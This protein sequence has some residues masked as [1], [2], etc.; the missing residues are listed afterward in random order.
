M[1]LHQNNLKSGAAFAQHLERAGYVWRNPPAGRIGGWTPQSGRLAID[2]ILLISAFESEGFNPTI[3]SGTGADGMLQVTGKTYRGLLPE[4]ATKEPDTLRAM[5]QRSGVDVAARGWDKLAAAPLSRAVKLEVALGDKAANPV[6]RKLVENNPNLARHQL[7][8][9]G[10]NVKDLGWDKLVGPELTAAIQTRLRTATEFRT[11]VNSGRLNFDNQVQYWRFME[12][13]DLGRLH[14]VVDKE[15][16]QQPENSEYLPIFL[17]TYH[18]LGATQARKIIRALVDGQGERTLTDI[19]IPRA[20]PDNNPIDNN[21]GLTTT[22]RKKG[23][24]VVTVAQYIENVRR[25]LDGSQYMLDEVKAHMAAAPTLDFTA[26]PIN[27]AEVHRAT[28]ILSTAAAPAV[29]RAQPRRSPEFQ[30]EPEDGSSWWPSLPSFDVSNMDWK[31]PLL[32][33]GAGLAVFAGVKY[34]LGDNW[35]STAVASVL[36]VVAGVVGYALMSGTKI[37]Y[38]SDVLKK[39]GLQRSSLEAA[40]DADVMPVNPARGIHAALTAPEATRDADTTAAVL[41][42]AQHAVMRNRGRLTVTHAEVVDAPLLVSASATATNSED[43]LP[44][45][46]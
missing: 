23:G 13:A 2:D 29:R 22:D 17:Y 30:R 32:G 4:I 31:G 27:L 5:L 44:I 24:P 3:Q 37:P 33:G 42:A 39:F 43:V 1:A 26:Q 25:H 19:G 11:Q 38:V 40:P 45:L 41:D 28:P 10:L 18:N 8:G 15:W 7:A 6:F 35:F 16:L 46:A 36:G 34:L 14:R 9:L 21:R 20:N 12:A